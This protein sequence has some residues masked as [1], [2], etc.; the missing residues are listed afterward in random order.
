MNPITK[1]IL[2]IAAVLL[3]LGIMGIFGTEFILLSALV[4][5][6][7]GT[8]ILPSALGLTK[9]EDPYYGSEP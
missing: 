4:A 1:L 6:A 8:L 3:L 7:I 2:T 5:L 9:K